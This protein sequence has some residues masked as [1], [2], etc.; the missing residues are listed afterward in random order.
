MISPRPKKFKNGLIVCPTQQRRGWSKMGNSRMKSARTIGLMICERISKASLKYI[1][2]WDPDL[3]YD[4]M[5]ARK[6][7]G[8][9]K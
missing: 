2:E 3:H 7:K 8:I 1:E 4:I 6:R 5:Q 9:K